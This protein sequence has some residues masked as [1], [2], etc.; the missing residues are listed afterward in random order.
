MRIGELAQAAGMDVDTVRYYEKAGLLPPASRGAN[1]YRSYGDA[2][3]QRLRFIRNCRALDMSLP[4]VR[5]LLDYIDQPG[6]DC[7]TV[8]G[9]VAEH[10]G[11]VR[12]RL[13]SLKTLE[14]QLELLQQA[15]SH[16]SPQEVCG[17]VLALSQQ[18]QG[19]APAPPAVRGVHSQ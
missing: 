7:S 4:E 3:L 19:D 11:H 17:I 12:E 2:A 5:V 10:L 15:C 6:P 9:V 14:R 1:N 16:A 13:A 8:D 18:P